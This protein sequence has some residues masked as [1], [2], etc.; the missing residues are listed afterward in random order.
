MCLLSF[1]ITEFKFFDKELFQDGD[2]HLKIHPDNA[3]HFQQLLL[4]FMGNSK[5]S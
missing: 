3:L 5:Y 2:P 4:N 1:G